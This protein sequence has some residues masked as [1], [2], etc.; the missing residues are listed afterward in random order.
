MPQTHRQTC[1]NIDDDNTL[2]LHYIKIQTM[3]R[4]YCTTYN[5]NYSMH[6][7]C[8]FSLSHGYPKPFVS[9]IPHFQTLSHAQ[10]LCQHDHGSGGLGST[11]GSLRSTAGSSQVMGWG[12]TK[13]LGKSFGHSHHRKQ[14]WWSCCR[15]KSVSNPGQEEGWNRNRGDR[16]SEVQTV[17]CVLPSLFFGFYRQQQ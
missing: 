14:D 13:E 6:L 16:E 17:P 9:F 2:H 4:S 12:W 7:V 11:W 10:V 8:Y 3:V 15:H 1:S 5:I